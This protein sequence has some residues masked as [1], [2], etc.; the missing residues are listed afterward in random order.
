LA[1]NEQSIFHHRLALQKEVV[2]PSTAFA[3]P[4]KM[5]GKSRAFQ[6]EAIGIEAA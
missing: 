6:I 2:A 3:R 5:P 4:K 1:E